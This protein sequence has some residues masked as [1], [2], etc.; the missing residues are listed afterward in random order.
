MASQ[1]PLLDFW[2]SLKTA[3]R[4]DSDPEIRER[5]GRT[6]RRSDHFADARDFSNFVNTFLGIMPDPDEVIKKA[7]LNANVYRE[8]LTD[9]HA[10]GS[11]MQRKSRVKRMKLVILAGDP[12]DARSV[13]A[14]DLVEE[15]IDNIDRMP[16]VLNE[17]L[18]APFFGATY[19]EM[20]WSRNPITRATPSGEIVL[21]NLMSKPFEW[22][23]W[24][25]DGNLKIKQNM[26]TP[27]RTKMVPPNKIYPVV[28]DGTYINPYGERTAKRAYWPFLFKKGGF[29]FWTEFLE[30][31]GSPFLFGKPD[32]SKNEDEVDEF[33]DALVDMVRNGVAISQTGSQKD[34]I[35]VV[36]SKGK[37]GSTD[38]H[39]TYKNAMNIEISKAILGETL[40]IEN[41]ETGSQAAT[42]THLTVLESIQDEDKQMAEGAY[43][44]IFRIITRLNFGPDVKAPFALLVDEEKINEKTAERDAVLVTK[45]GVRFK[46]PYIAETYNIDE[47][48]FELKDP[49]D[50]PG[51]DGPPKPGGPGK[52][53]EETPEKTGE[54]GEEGKEGEGPQF[55]EDEAFAMQ[56]AIDS[57]IEESLNR[58]DTLTAPVRQRITKIIKTSKNFTEFTVRMAELKDQIDN[59]LFSR[60][61]QEALG[62]AEVAGSWAVENNAT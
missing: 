59:N 44:G 32:P 14:R 7:G 49:P 43:S 47:D 24:D 35:E 36:E 56:K 19:L 45:I 13:K 42:E 31:Y 33:F 3:F 9:A 10:A 2:V 16:N 4:G 18:D 52:P 22:F 48:L 40:T 41:S 21:T 37:A 38:A 39:K 28:K 8:I 62:V 17:I 46:K 50:E 51:D 53:A 34:I 55:A 26:L 20:F 57:Y 12:T 15:Q 58:Y 1:S 60:V 54:P 30:K 6:K 25:L 11:I 29:R 27:L 61:F 5:G 23:A